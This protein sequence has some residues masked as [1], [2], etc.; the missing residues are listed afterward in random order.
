MKSHRLK[1]AFALL[2]ITLGSAATLTSCATAPAS[3]TGPHT[4]GQHHDMRPIFEAHWKRT[5]KEVQVL[6]IQELQSPWWKGNGIVDKHPVEEWYN[7]ESKNF[8]TQA[9]VLGK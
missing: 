4:N 5:Y 9:P 8:S 3:N 7:A 2:A 6:Q 1:T